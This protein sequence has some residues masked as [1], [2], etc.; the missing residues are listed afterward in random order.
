MEQI[1][2]SDYRQPKGWRHNATWLYAVMLIASICAF[3]ASLILSADTLQLARHPDQQLGCDVNG[4]VSCSTVAQSW[5]AEIIHFGGL[6]YPNAF[7]GI[8]AEAVFITVAV[9]GLSKVVFPRWFAWCTWAGNLCA[10]AYAYW[11]FSQSA[12]VIHALCPWCLVLMFTTT[13]QFIAQSHATVTVQG[14]PQ[15]EGRFASWQRA[16]Q[17]YYRL[18][19]D[20]LV[21][22]L[23]IAVVVAIILIK[24]GAAI[25]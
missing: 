23:W 15:S 21:D 5:Q 13:I 4:A 10:F 14:I 2:T 24:Y 12:F 17:T 11:L 8:A 3:M 18:G 9:L 7:F 16:L 6:S 1:T 19:A 25:L 22:V 20:L